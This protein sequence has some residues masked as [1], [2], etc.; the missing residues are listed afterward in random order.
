MRRRLFIGALVV[1]E[2]PIAEK[3]DFAAIVAV[4]QK[5]QRLTGRGVQVHSPRL[6]V[7]A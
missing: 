1:A 7:A 6:D 4:N 5:I 2:M 3:N